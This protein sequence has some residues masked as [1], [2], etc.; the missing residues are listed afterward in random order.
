MCIMDN[1]IRQ[2]NNNSS[3]TS[4]ND[5]PKSDRYVPIIKKGEKTCVLLENDQSI[6]SK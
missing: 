3:K 2:S 6:K 4:S 5:Q 1:K